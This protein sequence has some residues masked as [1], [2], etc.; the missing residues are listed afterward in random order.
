M[1]GYFKWPD[2]CERRRP[3]ARATPQRDA[4]Q[5]IVE[6]D[7]ELGLDGAR[8]LNEHPYSYATRKWPK[9]S[10]WHGTSEQSRWQESQLEA[11]PAG[12]ECVRPFPLQ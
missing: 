2:E 9:R 6:L 3:G 4:C 7:D 1:R 11:R 8:L 12:G 10:R 5:P